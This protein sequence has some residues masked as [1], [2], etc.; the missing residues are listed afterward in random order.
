MVELNLLPAAATP[1]RELT[2][3]E[4]ALLREDL[5]YGPVDDGTFD[6]LYAA[7]IRDRSQQYWTTTAVARQAASLFARHDARRVL[8]VGSG[9]GKF[10]LVAAC[11]RP[12]IEF[13]GVE[14]RAHLVEAARAAARRLDLDNVRFFRAD[15]TDAPWSG[16]DGF[17]LYNPFAENLYSTDDHLD[18]TVELS[19][20]R[21]MDD[22]GRVI[23]CLADAATGTCV[24]TYNGFGGPIPATFELVHAERA[25]CDWLRLWV[26]RHET[27]NPEDYYL[28]EDD[29]VTLVRGALPDLKE[30]LA[31]L[32]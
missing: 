16:F 18:D 14:H 8:D 9:P 2:D 11:T 4:V 28:E 6:A 25:G 32:L 19:R 27:A 5:H 29:G 7:P 30:R 24:V 22:V 26:K 21:F 10:C 1:A 31:A 13:T 20:R 15:A 3:D 23:R 12:D 17:Y